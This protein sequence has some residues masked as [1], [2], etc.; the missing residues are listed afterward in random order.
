[1]Y[2]CRG[3]DPQTSRLTQ[4]SATRLP[5]RLRCLE[6]QLH[7]GLVTCFCALELEVL[8]RAFMKVLMP[9]GRL[10]YLQTPYLTVS[11]RCSRLCH[12]SLRTSTVNIVCGCDDFG[13]V[14]GGDRGLH[15]DVAM[16]H[17]SSPEDP[18]NA[19]EEF[20]MIG[21][22]SS[23]YSSLYNSLTPKDGVVER[24]RVKTQRRLPPFFRSN[25]RRNRSHSG[26]LYCNRMR[27]SEDDAVHQ[28]GSGSNAISTGASLAWHYHKAVYLHVCIVSHLEDCF[29]SL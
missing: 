15:N 28:G 1:M 16:V 6:A 3:A 13:R 23:L 26:G 4:A 7:R 18:L 27:K 5:K 19:G 10:A 25:S 9:F 12:A 24:L 11:G 22:L 17:S 29:P 8:N 2:D 21:S 20:E 14:V